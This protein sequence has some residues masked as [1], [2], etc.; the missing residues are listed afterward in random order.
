MCF[1]VKLEYLSPDVVR[2]SNSKRPDWCLGGIYCI[3]IITQMIKVTETLYIDESDIELE[4]VRSSGPGGQ[5]V[6]KVSTTVQLRYNVRQ[7]AILSEGAQSRLKRIAGKKMTDDGILMIKANRFRSQDKNRK[8]AIARL[9]D[10]LRQALVKPKPRRKTKPSRAAKE[11]RL[12][13]K[14]KR[15]DLKR[16]RRGVKI[17]ENGYNK[18]QHFS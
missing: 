5:H 1:H 7:A 3:H 11:R 16:Q 10:L 15:S 17:S 13:A 9:V 8:D 4:F 2:K 6:N 18:T 12:T 14:K